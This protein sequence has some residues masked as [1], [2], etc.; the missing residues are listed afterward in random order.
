MKRKDPVEMPDSD[1]YYIPVFPP[2]GV[3]EVPLRC[4]PRFDEA[5]RAFWSNIILCQNAAS[6]PFQ[7]ATA[8]IN[9]QWRQ[10]LLTAE[11]I[12][13]G[14]FDA[15]SVRRERE[16]LSLDDFRERWAR[17]RASLKQRRAPIDPGPSAIRFLKGLHEH[18]TRHSDPTP[19]LLKQGAVQLWASIEVLARDFIAA[20]LDRTP[21]LYRRLAK[22]RRLGSVLPDAIPIRVLED[23]RYDLSRGMGSFASSRLP[24]GLPT[25]R[26]V[27]AVLFP[28]RRGLQRALGTRDLQLL[29]L[30]RH[31]LIHRSGTADEEYCREAEDGTNP[32]DDLV[33][34]VR[35]FHGYVA[36]VSEAGQRIIETA[37]L[38]H[39]SA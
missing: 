15:V 35:D 1:D 9:A 10:A 6:T 27:Y 7:L 22:N 30:R 25:L 2:L 14:K 24:T 13:A 33:V 31:V 8:A 4:E 32:G 21:E 28:K 19:E 16:G 36:A 29:H 18:E 38:A 17:A 37:P 26:R 12:R 3:W 34:S 11:R 20:H 23:Q 5:A 39:D